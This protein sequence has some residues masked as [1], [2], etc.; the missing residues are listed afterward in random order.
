MK[1]YDK[2]INELKAMI[3]SAYAKVVEI[4]S[5][6][7][8]VDADSLQQKLDYMIK[9]AQPTDQSQTQSEIIALQEDV[10][11]LM[12]TLDQKDKFIGETLSCLTEI[13]QNTD[14]EKYSRENIN[15][16]ANTR[17]RPLFDQA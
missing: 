2:E 7:K 6:G 9:M 3:N 12:N 11:E 15:E 8:N 1:R 4:R 10:N 17:Y 5:E 16:M 14:Q 13:L